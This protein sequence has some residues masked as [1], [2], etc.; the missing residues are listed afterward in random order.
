MKERPATTPVRPL[1]GPGA[2]FLLRLGLAVACFLVSGTAA[3]V[4]AYYHSSWWTRTGYAPD[5]PVP[6]SHRHHAGELRIDCRYCHSSVEASAFAGLPPTETCLSCHSQLFAD[7]ALLRPVWESAERGRPLT[8]SRASR[9]PDHVY[10]DH[11]IHVAKG[12]GCSSCHGDVTQQALA[13]PARRLDMRWCLD[14]H[15]DPAPALRPRDQIFSPAWTAPADQSARGASFLAARNVH[16]EPLVDCS[17]CH[18]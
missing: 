1:F 13:M 6:F 15:R 7:T 11:S 9:L 2:T 14:C 3:A 12:V 16:L 17:T 4:Y 5:Q 8:W 10:F 18:R